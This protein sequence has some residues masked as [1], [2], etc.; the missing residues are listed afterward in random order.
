MFFKKLQTKHFQL[1]ALILLVPLLTV[2]CGSQGTGQSITDTEWQWIETVE[3]EPAAQSLVPDPENYTI[4]FAANGNV[5]INADCNMS[6]GSYELDGSA[7]SIQLGFS[8]LAFCGEDSLDQ[9]FLGFL[10][11]VESYTIEDGQLVLALKDDAGRM[12][13]NEK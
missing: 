13:F 3:T 6:G 10:S 12:I 7:L 1:T 5:D 9:L 2:A 4:R 8:T 11:R